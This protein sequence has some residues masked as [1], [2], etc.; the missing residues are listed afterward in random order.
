MDLLSDPGILAWEMDGEISSLTQ[1]NTVS[2]RKIRRSYSNK[3]NSANPEYVLNFARL[4][5]LIT[6]GAGSLTKSSQITAQL[7]VVWARS[8]WKNSDRGS[9]PGGRSILLPALCLVLHG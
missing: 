1:Q 9:T 5:C 7:F 6:A 2:M 3:I 8:N 4:L